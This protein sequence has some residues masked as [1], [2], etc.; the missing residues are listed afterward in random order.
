MNDSKYVC[1]YFK[2][3]AEAEQLKAALKALNIHATAFETVSTNY[4]ENM[5]EMLRAA[6][7]MVMKAFDACRPN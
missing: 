4:A 7:E 1:V 5:S 3:N 2:S 6:H